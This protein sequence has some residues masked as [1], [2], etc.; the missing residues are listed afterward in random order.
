VSRDEQSDREPSPLD[1]V[2][3]TPQ[4]EPS[5]DEP[6]PSD[7]PIA[8]EPPSVGN[9]QRLFIRAY[10]LISAALLLSAIVASLVPT[11]SEEDLLSNQLTLQ[12]LFFF[13]IAC[14]AV[15][16]RYVPKLPGVLAGVVLYVCAA[17][18]G[19]TFTAF[20]A[21]IPATAIAYGFL[22]SALSFAVTAAVARWR[23]IDLS[24]TRGIFTLFGVGM[25][26]IAMT[27]SVLR[28][29]ANYWG[30]ACIAFVIFAVLASYYCDDI[31]DLDL[32]FDD[33]LS[34]W[35]SAVCGAAILYL[36]FINLYLLTIRF[37][38][39]ALSGSEKRKRGSW[40]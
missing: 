9:V 2:G 26:L 28:L 21:W 37:I 16:S 15:L 10:F 8:S 40:L 20:F 35:K 36:N 24:E 4:P 25:A 11:P 18:N 1:G 13:E 7:A 38:T 39:F 6:A 31:G 22:L 34:G 27:T 5:F 33:D 29:D 14:V 3:V 23:Q 12:F 30:T 17:I 19:A 32:E